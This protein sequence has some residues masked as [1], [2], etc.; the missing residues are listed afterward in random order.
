MNYIYGRVVKF[1]KDAGTQI[2]R[3]F[4]S[5]KEYENEIDMLNEEVDELLTAFR[6]EDRVE[7]ADALGDIIYVALG[8]MGKLGMDAE[9]ILSEICSSNES[10]YTD[11]CLVKNEN[12]KIQKGPNFRQ[13]D[14]SF[15]TIPL[16]NPSDRDW[17]TTICI[18]AFIA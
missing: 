17:E 13:P 8:T 4:L 12:G 1:N 10:K 7:I 16:P 3:K 5:V 2:G 15:V 9:R 6:E 18:L 11:G 14:L